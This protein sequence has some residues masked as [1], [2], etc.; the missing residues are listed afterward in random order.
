ML[1]LAMDVRYS[2][3]IFTLRR[4]SDGTGSNYTRGLCAS[5]VK[6]VDNFSALLLQ[7]ICRF[8]AFSI[9][10]YW[11]DIILEHLPTDQ[12]HFQ[13]PAHLILSVS[14][15]SV[16]GLALTCSDERKCAVMKGCLCSD[17]VR[18]NKRRL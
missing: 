3:R 15:A 18:R 1:C 4:A 13:F 10:P 5:H 11:I 17:E 12:S 6:R 14:S 9:R 7:S 16:A 8:L 2:K